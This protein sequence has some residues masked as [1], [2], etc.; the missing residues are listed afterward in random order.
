MVNAIWGGLTS[1]NFQTRVMWTL[2]LA[3][4]GVGIYML[5]KSDDDEECK[6]CGNPS[7]GHGKPYQQTGYGQPH[8]GGSRY[9]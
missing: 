5:M 8:G 3:F 9:L 4:V 7:H 2:G 6:G 1:N